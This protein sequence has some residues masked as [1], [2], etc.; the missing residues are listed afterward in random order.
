MYQ[1][2][3][4]FLGSRCNRI[5]KRQGYFI[6][7]ATNGTYIRGD[8]GEVMG[9]WRP[10]DSGI[11]Y[12]AEYEGEWFQG[13]IT[14]KVLCERL[15][16]YF[17]EYYGKAHTN[18]AA[19]AHFLTTGRFVECDLESHEGMAVV[20][21]GMR[22]FSMASKV[23]IGD[24][25]C[26]VYGRKRI[27]RSRRT[28]KGRAKF[29]RAQKK[30]HKHGTFSSSVPMVERVLSSAEVREICSDDFVQDFHFM[31]CVGKHEGRPMWISQLG[32]CLASKDPTAVVITFGECDPY[33]GND[34]VFTLIKKRR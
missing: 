2:S 22:P 18:C 3:K 28:H 23:D 12:I 8:R 27:T 14:D 25:V 16:T 31:V 24:M 32:H 30:R 7:L 15:S 29:V 13:N 19:L 20:H 4:M 6:R 33:Q 26:I 1:E 9:R 17:D 5:G 34:P 21:Q 10:E 11:F